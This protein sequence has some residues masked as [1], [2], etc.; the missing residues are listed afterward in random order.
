MRSMWYGTQFI[1]IGNACTRFGVSCWL[2]LLHTLW[3]SFECWWYSSCTWRSRILQRTLWCWCFKVT[4]AQTLTYIVRSSF[5]FILFHFRDFFGFAPFSLSS[6][7][8]SQARFCLCISL[9]WN[10]VSWNQL[11]TVLRISFQSPF[12]FYYQCVLISFWPFVMF[13]Y[14]YRFLLISLIF[15]I[16]LIWFVCLCI[17]ASPIH[18]HHHFLPAAMAQHKRVDHEN[19][20]SWWITIRMILLA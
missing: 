1:G 11:I 13:I 18:Y 6:C 7:C 15:V 19:A 2:F 20:N 3:H 8:M 16:F 10:V 4:Q 12:S 14:S 5:D 9:I 17:I